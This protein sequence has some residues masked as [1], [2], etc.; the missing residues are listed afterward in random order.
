MPDEEE[1]PMTTFDLINFLEDRRMNTVT[2]K[3]L[4]DRLDIIQRRELLRLDYERK[5]RKLEE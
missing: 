1:L 4:K 5:L 3:W 2:T